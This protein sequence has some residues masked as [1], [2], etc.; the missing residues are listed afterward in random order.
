M[1]TMIDVVGGA[2][3]VPEYTRGAF[4]DPCLRAREHIAWLLRVNRIFGPDEGFAR[5]S[6]FATAFCGGCWPGTANESKV[7][8]W[9]TAALRVPYQAIRRYE[10]LLGLRPGLIAASAETIHG[11]YC[12]DPGCPGW[13]GWSLPRH[14]PVPVGRISELI[15]KARSDDVM[16]GQDW[17]EVTREISAVPFFFISP[18]STWAALA[19]RLLQEQIVSDGVAWMQRFGALVRLL[20]HPVGQQPAIAACASLAADRANQVG[21]EVICALDVTGHPDASY[22]VL[23]QLACPTSDQTFY[24]ALLACVR[25]VAR[26]HFTAEQISYLASVVTSLL[27][28]PVRH[29]DA[30]TLAASLLRQ[31]PNGMPPGVAAKLRRS[32]AGD[33]VLSRVVTTG[34]LASERHAA[35]FVRRVVSAATVRMP[36][37]GPWL[38]DE[39]LAALVDE[40]LYSPVSDVRLYAAVAIQA[41]PYREPVA[42]ALG[43]ELVRIAAAA[44]TDLAVCIMDALRLLGGAQQRPILERFTLNAGLPQPVVASAARNIGHLGGTSDD[45]Y[46]LRAVELQSQLSQRHGSAEGSATLRGLVYGLGMA[47][48]DPLLTRIRD[49]P[50]MPTQA[51]AAASWWLSHPQRIRRSALV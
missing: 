27:D 47:R 5:A 44:H 25:K 17:D 46:W 31:M 24:G 15:D 51:R 11:Y 6:V 10:E 32:L 35:G 48:N 34:R 18:G 33:E 19:E 14:E 41:T 43:T 40:M 50:E 1:F 49:R 9:E 45:R 30:R 38:Y 3:T 42:A 21:I 20:G 37:E 8:R 26:G 28:D 22:H 2:G 7:S 36:R 4:G 12:P 29:D 16:T 13:D 39:T 23:G